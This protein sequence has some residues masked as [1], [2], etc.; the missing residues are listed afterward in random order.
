MEPQKQF[1]RRGTPD[2]PISISY[3]PRKARATDA[4]HYHPELEIVWVCAG[5]ILY[6]VDGKEITLVDGDILL[7]SPNQ[8]HAHIK[9]FD[10]T[11]SWY[12]AFSLEL[13]AIRED[14]VFQKEFVR[15]LQDG[16][17]QLPQLLRKEHPAYEQVMLSFD[18]LKYCRDMLKPNY[19]PLRYAMAVSLCAA[20]LPWCSQPEIPY[21]AVNSDNSVIQRVMSFIRRNYTQPLSLQAI[22]DQVHLHP[23]YLCA[24]FKKHTGQT[25]MYHLDHTRLDTAIFLLEKSQLPIVQIAERCG[26]RSE[27]V[28]YHKFKNLTGKTPKQWRRTACAANTHRDSQ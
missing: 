2:C 24:L 23:N 19:K 4:P 6:W 21:S 28:F 11:E 13:L 10:N 16:L 27:Y 14:H 7:I 26:Y 8:P 3:W 1:K 12:F 5:Q 20:L 15:P 17:L 25:V 22:A 18:W 9:T